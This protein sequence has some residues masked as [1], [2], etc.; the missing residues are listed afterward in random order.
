MPKPQGLKTEVKESKMGAEAVVEILRSEKKVV[1]VRPR[2]EYRI[3]E[4]DEKIRKDRTRREARLM[5]KAKASVDLPR[6]LSVDEKKFTIE[7]EFIDGVPVKELGAGIDEVAG[8]IGEQVGRLHSIGIAHN[9][10][11]TS[12][13]ISKEGRIFL[14]DF[15]LATRGR[16]E[17]FATD[18]KVLHECLEASHKITDKTW[19]LLVAGYKKGNP[20]WEAVLKRLEK[21]YS[22]GR[23]KAR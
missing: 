21:V 10:L 20:D 23:Y 3:K 15:G 16:V 11:T 18:L 4:L 17:D 2:K 8:R 19:G 22:R 13:M 6:V 7:M 5:N 1:K 14:I 12:N 9:D